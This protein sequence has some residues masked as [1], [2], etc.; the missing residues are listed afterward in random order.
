MNK[1]FQTNDVSV[2]QI[3]ANFNI[4]ITIFVVEIHYC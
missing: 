4:C 1:I 2:T 3:G